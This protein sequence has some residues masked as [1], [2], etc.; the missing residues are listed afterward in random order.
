MVENSQKMGEIFIKGLRTIKKPYIK[1][2]RG[3]GL[4]VGLEFNDSDKKNKFTAKNLCYILLKNKLLS[5]PTHENIIRFSPP[6]LM[7]EE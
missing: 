4:F 5:K 1:D 2:V 3:S 6:L 7:T